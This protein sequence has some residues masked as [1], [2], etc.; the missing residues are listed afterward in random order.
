MGA[1]KTA[2]TVLMLSS[3]GAK[4]LL[5]RRSQKRQKAD[6][7]RKEAGIMIRGFSDLKRF[8]ATWGIAIPTKDTGPAN[9]VTVADNTL[10]TMISNIL[11]PYM[12]MP[13]LPAY[14]VLSP[15]PT[16]GS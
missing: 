13:R 8:P 9:A 6:P 11:K 5:A 7:R 1:P 16:E 4:R 2:V 3:E 14:S 12:L 10:E 15:R